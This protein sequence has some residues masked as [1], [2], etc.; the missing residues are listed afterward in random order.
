MSY[1]RVVLILFVIF[2]SHCYAFSQEQGSWRTVRDDE[3][4][5]IEYNTKIMPE[6]YNNHVVWVRTEYH[7]D[8]WKLYFA[9]LLNI[10]TPIET[11]MTKA[12]YDKDYVYALVRQVKCYDK[13]G[14][15]LYDSGDD[16]SAG[17]AITNASDPVG[18]VAGV[19][20]P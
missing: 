20:A 1:L 9:S 5:K 11:I 14:K 17:W 8:D 18:I 13:N 19:L 6:K 2:Y 3:I 12:Q 16:T 7:T 15:L 4:S 10:N